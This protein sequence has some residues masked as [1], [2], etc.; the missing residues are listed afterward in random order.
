MVPPVPGK[1]EGTVARTLPSMLLIR[2][3][4][5]GLFTVDFEITRVMVPFASTLLTPS[6]EPFVVNT[7]AAP[8]GTLVTPQVKAGAAAS[9]VTI[10]TK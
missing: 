4:G 10:E 8:C 2:S 5:P 7:R 6:S 1:A 3:P 9:L